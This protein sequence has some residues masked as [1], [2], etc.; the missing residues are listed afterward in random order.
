M[1]SGSPTTQ[2]THAERAPVTAAV[3]LY[4]FRRWR[5]FSSS[6]MEPVS[7]AKS[8]MAV[9]KGRNGTTGR[10]RVK[11]A[12]LHYR[13]PGSAGPQDGSCSA[14]RR[15]TSVPSLRSFAVSPLRSGAA[16]VWKRRAVMSFLPVVAPE[17]LIRKHLFVSFACFFLQ[18]GN[19]VRL[20]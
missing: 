8:T 14:S 16:C 1:M 18:P 2:M 5:F 20:R 19:E 15:H 7:S 6:F 9:T 17:G 3:L 12:W 11:C 13:F 4:S 10:G